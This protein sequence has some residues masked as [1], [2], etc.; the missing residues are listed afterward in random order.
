MFHLLK[1]TMPLSKE[2][3]ELFNDL[4][5]HSLIDPVNKGLTKVIYYIKWKVFF[6]L[7]FLNR[8]N[9]LEVMHF[10]DDLDPQNAS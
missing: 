1:Q 4:I 2:E 3:C 7:R 5:P 8:S 10:Q 6:V 9:I